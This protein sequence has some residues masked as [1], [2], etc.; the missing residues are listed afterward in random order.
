M[1]KS[2]DQTS[3]SKKASERNPYYLRENKMTFKKKRDIRLSQ[4]SERKKRNKI[5]EQE[6]K[7]R[8]KNKREKEEYNRGEGKKKQ[9]K[10][11]IYMYRK[12]TTSCFLM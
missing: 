3:A 2:Q 1:K 7:E 4:H 11:E 12:G 9:K 6:T 10:K 5:F 8:A